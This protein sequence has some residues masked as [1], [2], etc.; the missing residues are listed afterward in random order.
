MTEAVSLPNLAKQFAAQ[1]LTARLASRHY[2]LRRGQ[3]V[4][5]HPAQ[6]S[7]NLGTAHIHA[8]AWTRYARQ[9]GDDRFIVV[10]VLQIHAQDL[11]ALFFRRLEVRD[12]ALFFQ[13]AGNLVL[14]L[15]SWYIHFLVPRANRVTDSREHVCDRI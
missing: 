3:D 10:A 9:I 4:D 8:A 12:I 11:V 15:G 14:Q 1:A 6:D 13:N 7:R 2:A 5:A